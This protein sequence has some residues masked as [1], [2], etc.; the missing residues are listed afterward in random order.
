MIDEY[1]LTVKID[2]SRA[3]HE[4]KEIADAIKFIAFVESVALVVHPRDPGG[5]LVATQVTETVETEILNREPGTLPTE[6]DLSTGSNRPQVPDEVEYKITV[7]MNPETT[8][9]GIYECEVDSVGDLDGCI[10]EYRSFVGY[11]HEG[12][13]EITSNFIRWLCPNLVG[14]STYPVRAITAVFRKLP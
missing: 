9:Q 10:H 11:K 7:D 2:Q 13:D 3:L 1:T 8:G 6:D 12:S 14:G 4:I 5:N